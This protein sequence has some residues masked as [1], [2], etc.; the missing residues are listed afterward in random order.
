MSSTLAA[1]GGSW[2]IVAFAVV[3]LVVLSYGYY[4]I[5]GSGI[6]AHPSDGLAGSPGSAG[7]SDVAKG[8]GSEGDGGDGATGGTFSSHGTG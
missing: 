3:M 5:K 1:V 6:D 8:R 2:I 7:P 4:S